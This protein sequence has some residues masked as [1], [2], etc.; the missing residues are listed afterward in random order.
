[1]AATGTQLID[2]GRDVEFRCSSGDADFQISALYAQYSKQISAYAKRRIDHTTA[3][4]VVAETFLTAWRR[5]EDIPAEPKTLPWLYG[6]CRRVLANQ[7]RSE[8]RRV[9]LCDRLAQ[10]EYPVLSPVHQVESAETFSEVTTAVNALPETDAEL[11]RLTAWEGLGPSEIADSLGI[12]P[13]AARQRLFR[14]RRR[15]S[16]EI[17]RQ[18]DESRQ[19]RLGRIGVAVAALVA[20]VGSLIAHGILSSPAQVETDVVNEDANQPREVIEIEDLDGSAMITTN[21]DLIPEVVA[22]VPEKSG[23]GDA[24]AAVEVTPPEAEADP[25]EVDDEAPPQ[26]QLSAPERVDV[27]SEPV[28]GET[29]AVSEDVSSNGSAAGGQQGSAVAVQEVARTEP[30]LEQT[31]EASTPDS[32]NPAGPFING[33]DLFLFQLDFAG[34]DDAQAVVAT[35]EAVGHYGV[36]PIIVAG[37]PAPA[38][39]FFTHDY[40]DVLNATWGTDW[41]DAGVDR[42]QVVEDIAQRWLATLDAGG[43]VWVAEGGVSDFTAEVLRSIRSQRP[44]LETTSLVHVVHHSQSNIARTQDSDFDFVRANANFVQI[45]DGNRA[46]RTANLNQPTTGF[47]AAA[48]SS[49]FSAGWDVAFAELPAAELDFSD[50]VTALYL[51]GVDTEL[52]AT[53]AD[54]QSIFIG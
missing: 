5:R 48:L 35:A 26:E 11:I 42:T 53:P 39:D 31:G 24:P 6:V 32:P 10:E 21:P 27:A 41:F 38:N 13:T 20:I 40:D 16:D 17:E 43:E 30:A 49:E 36:T 44:N 3:N 29:E 33:R 51:L 12:E 22:P 14:A 34:R 23:L 28:A 18:Q 37:T 52:V 7:R 45:D 9:R 50:T 2:S 47:E 25:T 15:L 1:M 46:N 8:Q 19:A 54:F 4:D